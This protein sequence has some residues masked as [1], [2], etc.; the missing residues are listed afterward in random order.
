[1]PQLTVPKPRPIESDIELFAKAYFNIELTSFQVQAINDIANG[2]QIANWRKIGLSTAKKVLKAYLNEGLTPGGRRRLP[3]H[4]LPPA[5]KKVK[6]VTQHGKILAMIQRPDGAYNF[7][8][9]RY[10]LKYT[11]VISDLRKEGHDIIADRQYNKNG[12]ASNTW[13]YR[14]GAQ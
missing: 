11:S 7:E 6:G 4:S 14:I 8:L 9:S 13:C 1:M 12:K 2:R 10:A 3:K 5:P